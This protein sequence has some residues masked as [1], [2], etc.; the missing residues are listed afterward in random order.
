MNG[1]RWVMVVGATLAGALAGCG[2]AVTLVRDGEAVAGIQVAES[3][4]PE[5]AEAAR[6]LQHFVKESSGATLAINEPAAVRIA[7][8]VDPSLRASLTEDGYVIRVRP[9]E[10]VLRGATP[11]GA[12][13]ATYWFLESHVGC[14]WFL[15]TPIGTDIPQQSTIVVP[16]GESRYRPDYRFRSVGGMRQEEWAV[17]NRLSEGVWFNGRSYSKVW[18]VAHTYYK[19]LPHEKYWDAHPEWY[20]LLNGKRGGP[21]KRKT[22]GPNFCT[23][24]PEVVAEVARNI[25]KVFDEDPRLEMVTLGPNDGLNFCTCPK[26]QA[27]DEPGKEW[28]GAA[29]RLEWR[30]Q[31][32]RR[33]MLFDNAVARILK[34]THPDKLLKVMMYSW[35]QEPPTDP[36]LRFEDNIVV[37]L[38]HS[39]N[40]SKF[41]SLYPSCY[42]HPLNDPACRP[43]QERFVPALKS[44]E[45]RSKT[46]GVYEYYMKASVVDT[47]FPIVHTI[48]EDVPYYHDCNAAYFHT[49][50]RYCCLPVEGLNLY[51][52]ARLMWDVDTD[53][54]A[55]LEDFYTRFYREAAGPMRTY[56]ERLESLMAERGGDVLGYL[57]HL[58]RIYDAD[59]QAEL[60]ALLDEGRALATSK[61]VRRRIRHVRDEFEYT[62]RCARVWSAVERGYARLAAD[63]EYDADDQAA[64]RQQL[65]PYQEA[66]VKFCETHAPVQYIV[67]PMNNYVRRVLTSQLVKAYPYWLPG[68]S[69][70]QRVQKDRGP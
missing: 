47:L 5:V 40:P 52:A 28:R 63:G 41:E 24:N 65:A 12:V 66:A 43:N 61:L 64:L 68:T 44:W 1:T 36:D 17:A 60:R 70:E 30:G 38:T 27:Q 16:V 39:G 8:E 51:V 57:W 4:A 35:Y 48:R 45:A 59:T 37:M 33:M 19:L 58:T 22:H 21:A 50:G 62:M 10:V 26:C 42:N 7:I 14:R 31:L 67:S 3:A 53:V 29:A 54:D 15:P 46:M 25:G 69:G 49:Q 34:R 6:R 2:G 20:A 23:S 18:G 13:Y 9:R 55:L 11:M 56:H 32:S